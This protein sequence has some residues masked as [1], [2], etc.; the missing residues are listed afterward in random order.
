MT[1]PQP[2][3]AD[4]LARVS[5]GDDEALRTLYERHAPA[6]MAFAYHL[7][8]D[9]PAAE[10]AVQETFL[11]VWRAAGRFRPGARLE[12]WLYRIARN[13]AFDARARLGRRARG[14]LPGSQEVVDEAQAP[15]AGPAERVGAGELAGAL[16]D[17]V[18]ALSERLR[19]AFVLVRLGGRSQEEAGHALGVPVGTVK[20]RVAAAEAVLRRRLARFA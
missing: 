15:G 4:L 9:R 6:L 20:S 12:P 7:T 10:D 2:P 17:A 13:E 5:R 19:L 8:W 3:D 11:K 18:D 14:A 16:R 1:D